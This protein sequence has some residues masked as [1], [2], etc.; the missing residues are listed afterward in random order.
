VWA[1]AK[2]DERARL[3]ADAFVAQL[4]PAASPLVLPAVG[5]RLG[6]G[7]A[8]CIV[9][10]AAAIILATPLAGEVVEVNAPLTRDGGALLADPY[11]AGWLV[12]LACGPDLDARLAALC[13]A[14]DTEEQARLELR[15]LRRQMAMELLLAAS[16]VG[17]SMTDGGEPLT[18]LSRA[19]SRERYL[20]LL[21]E[22]LA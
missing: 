8:V 10:P 9:D 20:E 12:E 15:H 3:G 2:A 16:S 14:A 11:G 21:R 17:P 18:D 7:A 13:A 6:E 4:L 5:A 19:M 1:E 22:V